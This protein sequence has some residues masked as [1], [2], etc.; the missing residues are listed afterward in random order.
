M[1]PGTSKVLVV[2]G[3][4]PEAIKMAPVVAALKARPERF[5]TVVAVTA[6]HREML[7][8]VT[9]LFG[10]VPDHDLGIMT[11]GQTLADVLSRSVSGLDIVFETERPDVC[12]VQGDTT[13]T[14][15]AAVAAFYRKVPVGHVEAGLRSFDPHHPFP[16]EINRRLTSVCADWHFAPT[17]LAAQRL[18]NEGVNTDRIYVTGNTVID[19]LL[20]VA[21]R[22]YEFPPGV[23]RDAIESGRRIVLVTLHRRENWGAP[24]DGVCA[25]LRE[26]VEARPDIH[27]LFATHAN[28]AIRDRVDSELSGTERIDLLDPL[29]YLPFVKLM[30]RATLILSDSGGI[31][32]EAPSLGT[33]VLVMRDVTER[34]EAIQAGTVKLVGTDTARIVREAS[35]L[36]DDA[37]AY[38]AMSQAAN[39]FGDG[40]AALQIV[41]IL[42]RVVHRT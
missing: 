29:D 1:R 23:I 15:A 27:V 31:Q 10:I 3:T 11:H 8:Q 12:L 39:P 2:F 13:T 4:R 40:T 6:Q 41:E 38:A 14:F 37:G 5:E 28:P 32:E 7:D 30:D 22:D 20:Q 33:P 42:D 17:M 25:A 26:L 18:E 19:A 35:A 21:G 24:V 9:S 16:E 36:L 34:P